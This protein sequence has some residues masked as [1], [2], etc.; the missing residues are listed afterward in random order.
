MG[1]LPTV[2]T[3]LPGS[4]TTVSSAGALLP[5]YRPGNYYPR[6]LR[7]QGP[8]G[9]QNGG[10]ANPAYPPQTGMVGGN[11]GGG[12]GTGA[13]AAQSNGNANGGGAAIGNAGAGQAVTNQPFNFT[14][15]PVP[16]LLVMLVVSV[17]LLRFVHYGY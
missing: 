17:L 5:W 7:A 9:V 15:S 8:G 11:G 16:L 1:N 2:P 10:S 12:G 3:E 6:P 4:S 13:M 14:E